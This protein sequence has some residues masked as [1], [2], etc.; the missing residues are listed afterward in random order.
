MS[1]PLA[2]FR[3][4]FTDLLMAPAEILNR[5]AMEVMLVPNS[6]TAQK[7]SKLCAAARFLYPS[8]GE[9]SSTGMSDSFPMLKKKSFF[10][11]G[12]GET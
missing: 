12:P 11:F 2:D 1:L 10:L 7:H 5:C 9:A 3:P 6:R 8:W 4:L